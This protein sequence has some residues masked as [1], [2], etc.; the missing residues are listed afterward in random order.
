MYSSFSLDYTFSCRLPLLVFVQNSKLL[1]NNLI[2]SWMW[3]VYMKKN[4]VRDGFVE[5]FIVIDTLQVMIEAAIKGINS[6]CKSG[7][8]NVLSLW[9]G[10]L[11]SFR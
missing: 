8:V 9:K 7:K 3:S 5:L 6:E 4:L 1:K 2:V 10:M 11:Q